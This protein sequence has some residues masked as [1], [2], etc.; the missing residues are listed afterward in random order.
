MDRTRK[1]IHINGIVQGV[2]F[3][4]FVY[5]IAKECNLSGFVNNNST[6]VLVEI[7]GSKKELK[8]FYER[9]FAEA[10][11]SSNII[12]I[13]K[14]IV[15]TLGDEDFKIIKT[16]SSEKANTLISPDIATCSECLQEFFDPINRRYQ[17]PF[18]NCTNCGPRYTIIKNIPYDRPY[19]SMSLFTMCPF[20]PARI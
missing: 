2:G 14:D 9:L 3:R 15:N 20:V 5:R 6:G 1:R 16:E 18:I 7:E 10:P 11:P 4:P 19:T 17:Y 12:S 13:K 8:S